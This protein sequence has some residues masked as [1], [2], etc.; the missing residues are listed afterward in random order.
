MRILLAVDQSC[1]SESAVMEVAARL[2][3][4]G[5]TVRL[6]HAI[7]KSVPPAVQLCYDAGGNLKQANK[8]IVA[9]HKK[10]IDDLASILREWDLDVDTV[11]RFGNVS[12]CIIEEAKEWKADLIVLG[13]RRRS[14]L[15]RLLFGSVSRFVCEHA[16]CC[17][18]VVH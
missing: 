5:T 6:I 17:V 10:L 7:E 4:P 16:Y 15:T 3:E 9:H 11:I 14:T 18:E 8:S 1:S 2:W 13:S 12:K